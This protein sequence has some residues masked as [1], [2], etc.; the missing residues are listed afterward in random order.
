M[1]PQR[2]KAT[3]KYKYV[4][5]LGRPGCGKSAL[6]RELEQRILD[7]GQAKTVE[8]VDDFPKVWA[9]LL[10]DDAREEEGK[11]RLFSKRIGDGNYIVTRDKVFERIFDE[12]LKEV[13][14]DVL[15]ITKPD[16]VIFLEFARS[17]YVQAIQHFDQRIL[18]NCIAIYMQ[19][20][21]DTCWAR[22]VARHEAAIAKDGDD[23]LVPRKEMEKRYLYDDQ[24]AFVQYMQARHIPVAVVDNEAHGEEHLE[25]QVEQLFDDLF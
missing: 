20:S 17:S 25:R 14:A 23:H 8:R 3:M 15:E 4:F 22:N 10:Q 18:D 11:E 19:V 1:F 21:F 12:I 6:Y 5:L 16:H 7:S 13:N 9:R 24:E 2:S